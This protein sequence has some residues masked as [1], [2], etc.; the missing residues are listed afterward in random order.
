MTD[1]FFRGLVPCKLFQRKKKNSVFYF[2][3]ICGKKKKTQ[4]EK[5]ELV[6]NPQTFPG[7]KKIRYLCLEGVFDFFNSDPQ[8]DQNLKPTRNLCGQLLYIFMYI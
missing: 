3:R 1:F 4:I 8:L 6:S 2:F 5:I 7:K